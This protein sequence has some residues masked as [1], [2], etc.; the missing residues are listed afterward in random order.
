MSPFIGEQLCDKMPLVL[1]K[2]LKLV[3]R[4]FRLMQPEI[5]TAELYPPVVWSQQV[6]TR[7]FSSSQ[8][9]NSAPCLFNTFRYR[10]EECPA[11]V[12][13]L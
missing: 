7:A 8:K 11:L 3:G 13:A 6:E 2:C 9:V 1:L 12:C 5:C 4:K 10:D